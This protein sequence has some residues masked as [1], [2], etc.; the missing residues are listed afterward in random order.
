MDAV[1][2]MAF[3]TMPQCQTTL[4][5][6]TAFGHQMM[7]VIKCFNNSTQPQPQMLLIQMADDHAVATVCGPAMPAR[8]WSLSRQG[9]MRC[10]PQLPSEPDAHSR[11]LPL[12]HHL[13]LSSQ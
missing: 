7:C 5:I 2:A 13:I 10:S 3:G 11:R 1:V 8:S 4:T 6:W 12:H 9:G